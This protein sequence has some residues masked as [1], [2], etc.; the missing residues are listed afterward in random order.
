MISVQ[1][2]KGKE[3]GLECYGEGCASGCKV[4]FT[5]YQRITHSNQGRARLRQWVQGDLVLF[6]E[7]IV[8]RVVGIEPYG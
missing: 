7:T 5:L 3:C 1:T 6:R 4:L 8:W 2:L